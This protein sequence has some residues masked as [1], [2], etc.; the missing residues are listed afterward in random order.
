MEDLHSEHLGKNC[1]LCGETCEA[2]Q[3]LNLLGCSFQACTNV[4]H[5]DCL[6][7]YLKSIRC[8]RCVQLHR[9]SA[10]G[11]GSEKPCSRCERSSAPSRLCACESEGRC[12]F[13]AHCC[14]PWAAGNWAGG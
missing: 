8:E 1:D 14:S 3:E 10:R 9:E 4:Y 11:G 13:P 6:E 2:N 7:R 12:A 5:Q